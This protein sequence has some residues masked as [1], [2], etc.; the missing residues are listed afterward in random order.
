MGI[1]DG[2]SGSLG[3]VVHMEP[4]F[5]C[6]ERSRDQGALFHSSYGHA[7]ILNDPYKRH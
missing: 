3:H 5:M 7:S 2:A 6:G 1:M 4:L